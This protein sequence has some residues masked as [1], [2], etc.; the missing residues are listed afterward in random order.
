MSINVGYITNTLEVYGRNEGDSGPGIVQKTFRLPYEKEW[1]GI[2]M[3][4][5]ILS[6]SWFVT[7]ICI[8]QFIYYSI[9]TK[10]GKII[11]IGF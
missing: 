6:H 1:D 2:S 3:E 4:H 5:V 11:H 9:W 8:K 10:L 7:L